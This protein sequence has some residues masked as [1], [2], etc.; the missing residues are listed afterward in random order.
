MID[1]DL[2]CRV[3]TVQLYTVLPPY[4]VVVSTV[5]LNI[6]YNPLALRLELVQCTQLTSAPALCMVVHTCNMYIMMYMYMYMCTV[7]VS[8]T[9]DVKRQATRFARMS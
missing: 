7:Y 9:C 4:T 6:S 3:A 5:K 1:H 2:E 8:K